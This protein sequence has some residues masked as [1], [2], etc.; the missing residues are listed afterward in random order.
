VLTATR[1][2]ESEKGA[3]LQSLQSVRLGLATRL[4]P[5]LRL[6]SDLDY[7]R[8][9][10]TF[11]GRDRNTWTWRETLEMQ[12]LQTWSVGG[13]FTWSSNTTSE[14]EP[15][16][17]RT[18]Y[19]VFTTWRATAYLTMGGTWWYNS[20]NGRGSL[21]QSYNVS[22]APGRKL[23]FSATYQGFEGPTG[24]GTA[25]DSLGVTYRLF[26]RFI[27]FAN[28]SRSRTDQADGEAD[29]ITNLRAGLRLAF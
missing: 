20:E 12:P 15:L 25:T 8:L 28:L 23:A 7:S 3:P 13:G 2:N 19:R 29:E 22:Y 9:D 14:G 26:T 6:V 27:L 4:L 5:D 1:R 10:D 21:N 11:A 17:N 16:L 18:Q 24:I